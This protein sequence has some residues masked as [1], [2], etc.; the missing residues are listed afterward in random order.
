[1]SQARE[2]AV[3]ALDL[4]KT[5]HDKMKDLLEEALDTDEPSER[6]DLLHQIRSELMAHE[7]M[8]E[9]VFYPALREHAKA[10]DIVLEGYEEHHVI[11]LILDELL[12]VP[13]ESDLWKAKL[14]VLQENI[15]HHIEEEEGEMFKKARQAFEKE[16]LEELGARMQATRETATA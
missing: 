14:K 9:E 10:K 6:G 15:E 8:E 16:Q 5:D 12:D 3:N 4:I 1:M 2:A 11:D 13:E 7:H